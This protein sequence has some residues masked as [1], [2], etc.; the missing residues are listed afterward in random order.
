MSAVS[1]PAWLFLQADQNHLDRTCLVDELSGGQFVL[2]NEAVNLGI[3]IYNIRRGEGIRYET[4]F[5]DETVGALGAVNGKEY[6][7]MPRRAMDLGGS[8]QV[9]FIC[10]TP[11][12]WELADQILTVG[13]GHAVVENLE[14]A[15]S[16]PPS[17]LPPLTPNSGIT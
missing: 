15:V 6:V 17:T 2:V 12:V 5:R 11:L 7:R 9:M 13:D 14:G 16:E 8:H 10:H 1:K 3:A 4:L